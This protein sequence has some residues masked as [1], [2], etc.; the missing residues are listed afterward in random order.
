MQLAVSPLALSPHTAGALFSA[1]RLPTRTLLDLHRRHAS[2]LLSTSQDKELD[3]ET[4]EDA[5]DDAGLV[6]GEARQHQPKTL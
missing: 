1:A 5:Q 2:P 3:F 6:H 4:A